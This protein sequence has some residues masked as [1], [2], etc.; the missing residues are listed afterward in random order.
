MFSISP[1]SAHLDFVHGEVVSQ[2]SKKCLLP[3]DS[4]LTCVK[5]RYAYIKRKSSPCGTRYVRF[6]LIVKTISSCYVYNYNRIR[7]GLSCRHN[8]FYLNTLEGLR[9]RA[10]N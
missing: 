10:Y 5:T 9:G 3:L 4:P 6:I 1:S 7:S 2:R 8:F